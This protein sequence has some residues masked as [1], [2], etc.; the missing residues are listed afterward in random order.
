VLLAAACTPP[1]VI[2]RVEPAFPKGVDR[3]AYNS[4]ASDLEAKVRVV[5][6]PRGTATSVTMAQTTGISQFDTAALDAVR[7]WDF[8]PLAAGCGAGASTLVTVTFHGLLLAASYAPCEHDV[9][10]LH[11]VSSEAPRQLFGVDRT[12]SQQYEVA[13]LVNVDADGHAT[14]AS[15]SQ[16]SGHDFLDSS[17]VA[18]A[19]ASTYAPKMQGCRPVAGTFSLHTFFDPNP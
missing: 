3:Y 18:G 6:S 4:N 19:R 2:K 16:S 13:V 9:I 8:A 1:A 5:I 12:R 15:V 10:V 14:K 7:Q 17:V 11:T